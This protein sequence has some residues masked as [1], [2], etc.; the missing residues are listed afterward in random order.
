MVKAFMYSK[1]VQCK[2]TV[3][4]CLRCWY[5]CPNAKHALLSRVGI[6]Y[7]PQASGTDMATGGIVGLYVTYMVSTVILSQRK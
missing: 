1:Y 7:A 4:V 6:A 5:I 2:H 3:C